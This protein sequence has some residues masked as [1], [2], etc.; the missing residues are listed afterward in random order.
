MKQAI[1]ITSIPESGSWL[2]NCIKSFNGYSK[3]EIIVLCDYNY[4]L[5]K[6]RWIM[7]NTDLDEFCLI[8]D[9]CEVKNPKVFE[10]MFDKYKGRSVA[11]S[12]SPTIFG[13][14]LGK[15]RRE[16]LNSMIIPKPKTKLE[17][18]KYEISFNNEY[19]KN[20]PN[21]IILFKNFKDNYLFE[22]KFGRVNMKLENKYLIK[23]KGSWNIEM[24][25]N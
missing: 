18:V 22:N 12:D 14:Y 15:Y 10:I 11:L 20:D 13:M 7:N 23:W 17:N 1:V 8:H 25:K 6:L 21:A 5:G 9:T 16:I 19:A 4:E 24:I 3:Y 2:A